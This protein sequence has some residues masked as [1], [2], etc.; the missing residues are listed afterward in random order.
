MKGHFK[1]L[2]NC[3]QTAVCSMWSCW[4]GRVSW[5]PRNHTA[6]GEGVP[7]EGYPETQELSNRTSLEGSLLSRGIPAPRGAR[8][9]VPR[10]P[11]ASA[12]SASLLLPFF[13]LLRSLFQGSKSHKRDLLAGPRCKGTNP[14]VAASA[15]GREQTAGS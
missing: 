15:P 3:L 2:S 10:S 11:G 1:D 8:P 14:G 9:A 5:K 6:E 7:R 4:D 12:R 13:S